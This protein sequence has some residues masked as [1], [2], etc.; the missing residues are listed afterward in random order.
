[1]KRI[2]ELSQSNVR[3]AKKGNNIGRKSHQVLHFTSHIRYSGICSTISIEL[4]K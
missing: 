4:G 3:E 1:M 2:K